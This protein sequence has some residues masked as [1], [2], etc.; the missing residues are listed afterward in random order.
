[1]DQEIITLLKHHLPKEISIEKLLEK[2]K[3]KEQGDISFPCFQVAKIQKQ[4]PQEIAQNLEKQIRENLPEK[5]EEVKAIGPFVNFFYNNTK[6]AQHIANKYLDNSLLTYKETPKTI[7]IEYP[8][9]NTNKALHIGHS[10]NIFLGNTLSNVLQYAGHNLIKTNLNNDRGIAVCKAMLSYKL[11]GE[12]QTPQDLNLKPDEFVSH[13]YVVFGEKAKQNPELEHQAQEMLQQWEQG[14]EE[15]LQ[16]WK[17]LLK[18]VFEGYK[19]T[20]KRY[21]VEGFDKQFYESQ[22]YDKGKE[23]VY[24]AIKN[25]NAPLKQQDD[26]AIYADLEHKQLGTK[27]LLRGDGTSLYMTQDLYLAQLKHQLFNP[28]LSIFVVGQEQEYHFKVLFELLDSIN[29]TTTNNYHFSYG[30]VFNEHGKKF[31]SRLGE[32]ISADEILDKAVEKAKQ[33]LEEKELTKHLGESQIQK[34]A[35][36]IGYCS[37]AFSF[38]KTNPNSSINFSIN[39]ALSFEGETGAY[40]QYTY[41]RIQSLLKKGDFKQTTNWSVEYLTPKELEHIKI[42]EQGK[43]AIAEATQKFKLSAIAHYTL[44]LAQ[45]FNDLYAEVSFIKNNDENQKHA[46]LYLA[47]A[48]AQ[49]IKEMMKLYSI[50]LLEEM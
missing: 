43:E 28:D 22:I 40:V 24:N 45:S 4:S 32:T 6:L 50:E 21:K 46:R 23:I 7:L 30:Y 34:R 35:E 12:N 36:H 29:I 1:M 49:I 48:T 20:Y 38:L 26:G 37:L 8:S 2:P 42:F 3:K 14:D 19:Q 15:V 5:F 47:H 16:L 33:N 41:A 39:R 11:F 13:W 10:R 18:W 27:F 44:K 17:T 9:P 31:S 25:P